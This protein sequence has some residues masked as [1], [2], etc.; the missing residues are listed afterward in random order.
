MKKI[1]I[2]QSNYIPWK[3]YFDLMNQVDDFVIY[4][5]VQYTKNDWRNRNQI[6]SKNGLQWLTIPVSVKSRSQ[7][8]NETEIMN[9]VWVDK[10]IKTIAHTYAK[11]AHY[12]EYADEILAIFTAAKSLTKLSDINL[13]FIKWINKKLGITTNIHSAVDFTL[14]V[15]KVDRLVSICEQLNASSYLSGPAAKDYLDESKFANK[16]IAVEWM[17]YKDYSECKQ[18]GENFEHAVSVLDIIF[19]LG[20]EARNVALRLNFD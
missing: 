13:L 10:H 19:H 4:D 3:G 18:F 1:A 8:I 9:T 2:L 16:N 5:C 14:E 17:N 12:K 7:L 11:S 20:E 6:K 15:D